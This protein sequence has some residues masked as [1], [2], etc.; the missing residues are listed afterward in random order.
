MKL[1]GANVFSNR[2]GDD[3]AESSTA[4]WPIRDSFLDLVDVFSDPAETKDLSLSD[5]LESSRDSAC[6]TREG[7]GVRVKA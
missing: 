3:G 1:V 6:P 5:G 2:R 7:I 4:D